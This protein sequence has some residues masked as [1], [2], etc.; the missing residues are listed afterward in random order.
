V[1]TPRRTPREVL[2]LQ[3]L[4]RPELLRM[5]EVR[6]RM[7]QR[8]LT[9]PPLMRKNPPRFQPCS[10]GRRL[11]GYVGDDDDAL[12][13][14]CARYACA[15]RKV[16][17]RSSGA[18][19]IISSCFPV[20]G[21]GP[22]CVAARRP[23]RRPSRAKRSIRCRRRLRPPLALA[24]AALVPPPPPPPLLP[25]FPGSPPVPP[26]VLKRLLPPVR[27]YCR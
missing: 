25:G 26:P 7:S 21:A 12:G 19:S 13:A 5:F 11:D 22:L 9:L 18:A 17:A 10:G 6:G 16:A 20:G 15:A 14:C 23:S 24:T 2:W 3:G 27:R 8:I 4:R 1:T